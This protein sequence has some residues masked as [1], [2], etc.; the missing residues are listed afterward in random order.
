MRSLKSG[1]VMIAV[2]GGFAVAA[3]VGCSAE[4]TS[5]DLAEPTQELAPTEDPGAVLPPSSDATGAADAGKTAAKD[6]GKPKAD[7]SSGGGPV[8]AGPPPPTPGTACTAV[9][10]IASKACGK[11][12]EAQALCQS[13]K[14]WSQYGACEAESGECTPGETAPCGNCGTQTCD[15]YCG[16]GA[17]TGE[18][19]DSCALGSSEQSTIGCPPQGSVKPYR[20]RSCKTNCTWG[21]YSTT[22]FVPPSW[23][24]VTVTLP[25]ATKVARPS[26][27]D[28]APCPA[29]ALDGE[30]T[31]YAYTQVTNPTAAAVK[32]TLFHSK[33]TGGAADL[34]TLLAVYAGATAPSTLAQRKVCIG[35]I[36]DQS[37]GGDSALTGNANFAIVKDITIPANGTITVYSA[38]WKATDSGPITLNVKAQ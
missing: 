37:G 26:Y 34:D 32:V 30:A 7:A 38:A 27:G 20:T 8:D 19:V 36:G 10:A 6:A 25:A 33:A 35:R 11:C 24:P 2:S 5:S 28:L 16:W 22:C 31:S 13:N 4:G 15:A 1:L 23:T 12:G 3:I 21:D 18:P 17:C 14:T 9:N 29:T